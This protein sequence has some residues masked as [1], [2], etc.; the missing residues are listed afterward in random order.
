MA[1]G[2]LWCARLPADSDAVAGGRVESPS[3]LIPPL[4]VLIDVLPAVLLFGVG[5]SL[6]V[7]PLTS[8]LMGSIPGRFSGLG[9]AINNS[10]SRVGQPLLGALIFIAISATFYAALGT[11]APGPR[12]DLAG[13][14]DD[15]QPLN[16]PP[17]AATPARRPRRTRPR[18]RRSTWRCWSSA[19]LLVI[20]GARVLVRA[21]RAAGAGGAADDPADARPGASADRPA[22]RRDSVADAER[23]AVARDDDVGGGEDARATAS[24]SRLVG[25]ER[26]DLGRPVRVPPQVGQGVGRVV[27]RTMSVASSSVWPGVSHSC[28]VRARGW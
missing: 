1:V 2:L 10:I 5:I 24:R 25:A 11:Y 16:P 8:T 26:V 19:G 21:A 22:R 12:H 20:G 27:G 18:W 9:S 23:L 3:T 14:P 4:D 13:G 6:V 17:A 7:A 28:G 15:F